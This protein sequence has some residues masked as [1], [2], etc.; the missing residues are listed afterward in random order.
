MAQPV[1]ARVAPLGVVVV[2]VVVVIVVVV[3]ILVVVA[4]EVLVVVA[5]HVSPSRNRLAEQPKLRLEM[6]VEPVEQS[7]LP[8]YCH[9]CAPVLDARQ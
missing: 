8:L 3:V 6:A 5:E 7:P 4:V 2:A 1:V 9:R